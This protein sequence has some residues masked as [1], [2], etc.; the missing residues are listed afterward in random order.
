MT[1]AISILTVDDSRSMRA[2][3]R[4]TLLGAGFD[5]T[6][7]RDGE[8]ALDRLSEREFDLVITDIN[9]PR[10]DGF[11]FI[12]R[13]REGGLL[14]IDRPILVLSTENGP[15]KRARARDAG[16]TG[17]VVKPFDPAKLVAAIRRVTH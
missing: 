8:E 1:G 12:E 15:E 14:H 5:V 11:S 7:A 3:L 9:M 16:A 4:A 17:W 2:L 6:E 10:L 13:L